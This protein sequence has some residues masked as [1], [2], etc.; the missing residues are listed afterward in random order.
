MMFD[1]CRAMMS[2]G[3]RRLKSARLQRA[4]EKGLGQRRTIWQAADVAAVRIDDSET[5]REAAN[6]RKKTAAAT[7]VDH[8]PRHS[9]TPSA[10][11]TPLPPRNRS[12]Q[13]Y[14]C[15][16][17]AATPAPTCQWIEL[18]PLPVSAGAIQ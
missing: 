7:A 18:A 3:A 10:V 6:E 12:Q 1:R 17:M 16:K 4:I 15:P 13:G 11:A 14:M 8:P 2:A 9:T 5:T